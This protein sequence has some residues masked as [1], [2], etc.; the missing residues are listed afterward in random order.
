V[1]AL[2]LIPRDLYSYSAVCI[3]LAGVLRSLPWSSIA[4]ETIRASRRSD[5]PRSH[6]D[7]RTITPAAL[8]VLE[9]YSWP[10]NLN[11]LRS[12]LERA[13]QLAGTEPIDVI[14][15][16][17][18]LQAAVAST[19]DRLPPQGINLEQLEQTLIRQALEQAHGNKSRAA[20][21]LG[22]TRHTLLYRMEKYAVNP[23]ERE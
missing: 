2:R 18:R 16:P 13:N 15:L 11:E 5:E 6:T 7:K 19:P 22:L 21:L 9:Q 10:G 23:L 14:H 3:V 8:Q 1:L 20:E 17:E 12:V 4:I